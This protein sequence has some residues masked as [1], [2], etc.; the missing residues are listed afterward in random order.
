MTTLIINDLEMNQELTKSAM[1]ALRGKG[2][3]GEVARSTSRATRRT[4]CVIVRAGRA[5]GSIWV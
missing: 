4:R 1:L 3:L 2:W 5:L